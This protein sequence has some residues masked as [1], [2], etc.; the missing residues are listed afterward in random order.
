MHQLLSNVHCAAAI[1]GVLTFI[2]SPAKAESGS[3]SEGNPIC[4]HYRAEAV[5]GVAG[6]NHFVYVGNACASTAY[7]NIVM[8]ANPTP[9]DVTVAPS[10]TLAVITY[11]ES[12]ARIFQAKVQCRLQ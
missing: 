1:L 11:K 3:A 9:I 4:V 12:P 8:S 7:C 2:A 10:E 6:Y 5:L